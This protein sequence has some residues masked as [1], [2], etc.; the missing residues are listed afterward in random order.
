MR[1]FNLSFS[2]ILVLIVSANISIASAGQTF[3]EVAKARH[4]AT[5]THLLT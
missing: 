4:I 5:V 2:T 1:I 3:G